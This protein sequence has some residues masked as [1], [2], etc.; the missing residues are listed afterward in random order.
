MLRIAILTIS[1]ISSW[2]LSRNHPTERANYLRRPDLSL[3]GRALPTALHDCIFAIK[4]RNIDKIEEILDEVSDSTSPR[5]GQH[6]SRREVGALTE[7]RA[8]STAV[9]DFLRGQNIEI[10]EETVYGEYI[11][12]RAP[13]RSWENIFSSEFYEVSRGVDDSGNRRPAV[14]RALSYFIPESLQE[15]VDTVFNTVQMPLPFPDPPVTQTVRDPSNVPRGGSNEGASNEGEGGSNAKEGGS[16]EDIGRAPG[17]AARGLLETNG[18]VFP[19]LLNSF[20]A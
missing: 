7:N 12:A 18:H 14:A 5:Y 16:E 3:K 20:C 9:R 15:H 1:L 2:S 4:L 19:E 13:I 6:L 10:I 17:R 8:G 11:T